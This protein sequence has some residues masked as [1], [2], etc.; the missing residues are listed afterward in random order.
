MKD[1]SQ[2]TI[3]EPLP[4]SAKEKHR[5]KL[6]KLTAETSRTGSPD[7]HKGQSSQ[8][9]QV[10]DLDKQNGANTSPA[11]DD[12]QSKS[13]VPASNNAESPSCQSKKAA[14]IRSGYSQTGYISQ[15]D[16]A[17]QS[18]VFAPTSVAGMINPL[19]EA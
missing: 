16:Q 9:E 2:S 8:S 19:C 17:D 10:S 1:N 11:P 15:G 4:E 12:L 6:A 13:V 14:H 3:L 7:Q 18:L 5:R